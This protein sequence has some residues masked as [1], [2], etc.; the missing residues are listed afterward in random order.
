MRFK[1]G[2]LRRLN[3][4]RAPVLSIGMAL[5]LMS[6]CAEPGSTAT[7]TYKIATASVSAEAI[8]LARADGA[9]AGQTNRDGTAC[10]WLA[11]GRDE[12]ALSWPYGYTARISPLTVYDDSGKPVAEVGEIVTLAGGE[13]PD[14]VHSI[15][16]CTGF[17]KFWDVGKVVSAQ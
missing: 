11:T 9:L 3:N 8:N 16:G 1:D 7:V 5:F 10:F 15:A 6:A 13:S 12:I 2:G 17:T 14:A 4:V